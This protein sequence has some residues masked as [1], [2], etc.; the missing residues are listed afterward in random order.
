MGPSTTALSL[1]GVVVCTALWICTN[2]QLAV[3]TV[4]I[5]MHFGVE[6][7]VLKDSVW[8]VRVCVYCSDLSSDNA[9]NCRVFI[10]FMGTSAVHSLECRLNSKLCGTKRGNVLES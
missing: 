2:V 5:P 7:V 4:S 3:A 10:V 9:C 6:F 1:M 8:D